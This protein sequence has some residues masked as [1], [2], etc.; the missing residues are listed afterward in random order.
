MNEH[1]GQNVT[2][3]MLTIGQPVQV[4]GE[5]ASKR[6]TCTGLPAVQGTLTSRDY[7]KSQESSRKIEVEILYLAQ[8][9]CVTWTG[10]FVNRF[11]DRD[12]L[13]HFHYGL[14]VGHVYSHEE[15]LDPPPKTIGLNEVPCNTQVDEDEDELDDALEDDH[16]GGEEELFD[17]ENNG[18]SKSIVEK[19]DDIFVQHEYDYES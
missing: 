2:S 13:M 7:T 9:S 4:T 12:M 11:V 8:W 6:E 19:L 18:S 3:L 10:Y 16:T 5:E 17:Q 14:G 15:A 1:T